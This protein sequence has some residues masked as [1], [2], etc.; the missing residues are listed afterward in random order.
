MGELRRMLDLVGSGEMTAA[1]AAPLAVRV[2]RGTAAAEAEAE[3][4][5]APHELTMMRMAGSWPD[6]DSTD[7]W[8][9]VEAAMIGGTL[10]A[11]D[12]AV[13]RAAYLG[14]AR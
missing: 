7:T 9:E 13:L 2:M 10:S 6:R 12:Y 1:E 8:V 11:E 5:Y 3:A 4:G 14:E